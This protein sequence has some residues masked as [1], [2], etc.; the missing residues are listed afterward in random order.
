MESKY[1]VMKCL[2]KME[3]K[4]IDTHALMDCGATEIAFIDKDFVCHHQLEEKKL[5]E[6]R[7]IE[8]IDGRPIK[9]GTI[10]TM[11]KLNLGIRGHQEQLP[12]FITKLCHYS[13]LLG[14][15]W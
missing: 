2:L 11:T 7:E 14:L 13:I 5:Q 12:A 10:T 9:L 6:L 8:V 3:D 15:P 1:L 4:I